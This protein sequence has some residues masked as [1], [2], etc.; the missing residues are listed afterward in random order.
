MGILF[1]LLVR[2][3]VVGFTGLIYFGITGDEPGSGTWLMGGFF[4]TIMTFMS[5][6]GPRQRRNQ[7]ASHGGGQVVLGLMMILPLL[8]GLATLAFNA[9]IGGGFLGIA[10]VG[11]YLALIERPI[12]PIYSE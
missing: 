10:G 1:G 7:S 9:C 8:I 6:F 11:F 2:V 5:L 3:L 4:A 12:G